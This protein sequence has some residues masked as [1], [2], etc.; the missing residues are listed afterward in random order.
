METYSTTDMIAR[1]STRTAAW[2]ALYA[3]QM[4]RVNFV[5]AD[6]QAFAPE[7]RIVRLGQ[8]KLA[9]LSVQNCRVERSPSDIRHN[10][11][12]MYNFLLQA[13]GASTFDHCGR[14]CDLG[15]GDVVLCDTGH[16][17]QWRT[18]ASSTT[19]MFR[20]EP[21]LL[22][23]YLPTPEQ[24][25]GRHLGRSTGLTRTVAAMLQALTETERRGDRTG[26]ED[27]VARIILHMIALSYTGAGDGAPASLQRDAIVRYIEDHLRDPELSPASVA[28]GLRVS[29]RYL[30]TIFSISGERV[31][32][33]ILRRRLEECARQMR[34]P[35]WNGHTLTEIA[36]SWGFNSAAHFTRSF[37]E[38]YH[39]APRDYRRQ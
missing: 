22:G 36:F 9:R 20:I 6:D 16:P 11:P 18:A 13:E 17:H 25:C 5:P 35:A 30:R 27:R 14:R 7:L 23:E 21:R 19:I 12:R 31:S 26:H 37:Q 29:P 39:V 8:V 10:P 32:A 15:E 28:A 38:Q 4:S 2:N 24:F 33:Y 1:G 3:T 34:N